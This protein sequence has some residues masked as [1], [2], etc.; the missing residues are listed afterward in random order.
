MRK[1]ALLVLITACLLTGLTGCPSAPKQHSA[2]DDRLSA[3]EL[4]ALSD[5]SRH[6]ATTR[7]LGGRDGAWSLDD[8]DSPLFRRVVYFDFDDAGIKPEYM[9]LLRIHAQ[10]LIQSPGTQVI[11]EG[12]TDERGTREYNLALGE[13]RADSVRRFLIGEGVSSSQLTT[14][15]YGEERPAEPGRDER[16]MALN[17]RVELAY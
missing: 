10:Y 3:A 4:D 17:R 12:H 8:P 14:L 7:G 13:R 11:L 9:E 15:S 5:G 16:S 2:H 1:L 6:G